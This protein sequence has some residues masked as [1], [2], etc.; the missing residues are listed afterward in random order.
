MSRGPGAE[1]TALE[2]SQARPDFARFLRGVSVI[3]A[4][5]SVY[6]RL[7][8]SADLE[9]DPE[10]AHAGLVFDARGREVLEAVHREYLGIGP[11]HGLPTLV[12]ADT[13][14]ANRDRIERSRYSNEDV[15]GE[16]ARLVCEL[17]DELATQQAPIFA[18]GMLGPRGDAYSPGEAPGTDEAESFHSFQVERLATTGLDLIKG[19]TLP[20]VD[21]ALGLARAISRASLPYFLSFVIRPD[22]RVLDGT[23]LDRAIERIDAGTPVPPTGYYVN[24]VHPTIL[25]AALRTLHVARPA[26]AAPLAR[27]V[28]FHANTSARSPE[29][30]D[31]LEKI[32]TE[33]PE[34]FA[35][36]LYQAHERFGLKILG[37]CCGSGPEHIEHLA[38]VLASKDRC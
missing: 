4:E 1:T 22:G 34:T 7:R 25:S 26:S 2:S 16:C 23:P 10:I 33:D 12:L 27:L 24:C 36:L 30:L 5:G 21:E 38:R 11:R 9:W 19:A 35:E 8:R 31:G 28:G 13:W 14:R 6:E 18:G 15:N 37:G 32:D 20:A 29:E 3:L 17:R